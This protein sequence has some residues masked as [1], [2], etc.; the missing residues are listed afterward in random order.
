MGKMVE[1]RNFSGGGEKKLQ[2]VRFRVPPVL[3]LRE[4]GRA[5]RLGGYGKSPNNQPLV[6]RDAG[7][8]RL[9]S[10]RGN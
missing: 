8:P 4:V 3:P 6:I 7:G 1:G 5:V 10:S 2:G 9:L